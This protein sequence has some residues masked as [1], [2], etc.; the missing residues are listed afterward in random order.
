MC[1]AAKEIQPQVKIL[2]G[3][4]KLR[5]SDP[6]IFL[7][8]MGDF[9][10]YNPPKTKFIWLPRQDQLQEMIEDCLEIKKL[11]YPRKNKFNPNTKKGKKFWSIEN[12]FGYDEAGDSLE[13][14]LLMYVMK[15][16]FNKTWNG[17]D[18]V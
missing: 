13:Q 15:R 14:L 17:E 1:E 10:S 11:D 6:T 5:D 4:T 7:N 2:V 3:Y 9:F 16:N 18:W 12:Q 8:T